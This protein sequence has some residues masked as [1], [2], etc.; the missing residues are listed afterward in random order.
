DEWGQLDAAQRSLYW[1]VMLETC[2]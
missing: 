2:G 1:E